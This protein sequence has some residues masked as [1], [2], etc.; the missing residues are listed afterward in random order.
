MYGEGMNDAALSILTYAPCF[1]ICLSYWF[2][3]NR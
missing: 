3:G 2:L 1:M